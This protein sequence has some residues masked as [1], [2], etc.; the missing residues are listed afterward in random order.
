MRIKK[1]KIQTSMEKIETIVD[2]TD[3]VVNYNNGKTDSNIV[4][5]KEV[6][7]VPVK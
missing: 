5:L 7:Y 3:Y 4:K 1:D 6:V 2:I